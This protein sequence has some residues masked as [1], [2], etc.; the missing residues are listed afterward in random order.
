MATRSTIAVELDDGS[1][2][3]IY[4]HFDGYLSGVGQMLAFEYTDVNDLVGLMTLG[5]ISTLSNT[6]E[7][8]AESAYNDGSDKRVFPDVKMY[9]LTAQME[10][11]NY[12]YKRNDQGEYSWFVFQEFTPDR[13]WVRF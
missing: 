7:L 9:E 11:F 12:I 5:D 1:V 4:C 8:T 6:F 3:Q 10:E 13:G 2:E